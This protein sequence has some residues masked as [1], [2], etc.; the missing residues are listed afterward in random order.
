MVNDI[1]LS[2]IFMK[3]QT[4]ECRTLNSEV[5]SFEIQISLFD[6]RHF[7]IHCALAFKIAFIRCR[8][9]KNI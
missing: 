4:T 7:S 1:R 3:G 5:F 9:N 2:T 6:I 8:V